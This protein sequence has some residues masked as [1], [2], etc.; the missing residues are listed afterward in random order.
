MSVLKNNVCRS[1]DSLVEI[2]RCTVP[3]VLFFR[4]KS[5]KAYFVRFNTAVTHSFI[6]GAG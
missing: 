5:V 2:V 1:G 6:V 3:I 4:Y